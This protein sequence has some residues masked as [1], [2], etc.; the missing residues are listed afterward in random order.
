MAEAKADGGSPNLRL[1]LRENGLNGIPEE[2]VWATR[3]DGLN[4]F[5]L[6]DDG[7]LGNF[8]FIVAHE[9]DCSDGVCQVWVDYFTTYDDAKAVLDAHAERGENGS[10]FAILPAG[11]GA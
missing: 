3:Q 8:R 5:R 7:Y 1:S 4:A 2:R 11:F 9:K 6:R 10:I